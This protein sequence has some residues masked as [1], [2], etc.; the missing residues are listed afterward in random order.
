M[1]TIFALLFAVAAVG[2]AGCTDDSQVGMCQGDTCGMGSCGSQAAICGPNCMR[3][4]V[5]GGGKCPAGYGCLGFIT[6]TNTD[7]F[8]VPDFYGIHD[9][10]VK[11]DLSGVM[12]ASVPVDASDIDGSDSDGPDGG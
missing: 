11:A 7:G 4:K 5:P 3:M 8:T 10:T 6:C 9:M 2:A 12:D 1:K